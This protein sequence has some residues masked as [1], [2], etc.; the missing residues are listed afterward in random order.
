MLKVLV[1][2]DGSKNCLRAVEHVIAQN[3]LYKEPLDLHLLNV[4]RP[5]PGTVRGVREEAEK[6]HHDEGVKALAGARQLLDAAGVKYRYHI[7]VGEAA[8]SIAQFVKAQKLD[9]VV[10]GTHGLS[11]VASVLMGSVSS[12]VLKL[13]SVPL[14]LVK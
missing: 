12:E 3:G 5:F 6:H 11:G 7:T 14:V 2:I 10:M 4:Q 9:E 1:P 8:E 13:V